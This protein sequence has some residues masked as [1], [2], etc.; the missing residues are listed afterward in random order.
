MIYN[1]YPCC[2]KPLMI[3][4]PQWLNQNDHVFAKENCPHCQSLVMHKISYMNPQT[5]TEEEFNKLYII[6]EDKKIVLRAPV[7]IQVLSQPSDL[8][9]PITTLDT[10]KKPATVQAESKP[11]AP[12]KRGKGRPPGS[13]NK[14]K[15]VV[16]K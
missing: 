12:T 10:G 8:S 1:V 4:H 3:E 6:T 2:K 9:V 5:F 11:A 15:K 7:P 16:A 13:P 14:K